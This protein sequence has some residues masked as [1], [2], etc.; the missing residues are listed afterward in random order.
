M[1]DKFG[2]YTSCF[3][4]LSLTEKIRLAG[5][6]G[7]GYIEI[8]AWPA[9]DETRNFAVHDIDFAHLDR[10]VPKIRTALKEHGVKISAI[11][12]Y[13]NTLDR[14]LERRKQ[15][16]GHLMR[17]VDAARMLDC[18]LVSTFIG[19]N[20]DLDVRGNFKELE[21]AF[22]PVLKY[23]GENG[24][25]IAFENCVMEGWQIQGVPGTL[26]YQPELWEEIFRIL[27]QD[28]LGINFD[29]S[30]LAKQM[31]D[32]EAAVRK[33]GSRIF[34]FHIKD[35]V[36]SSRL[37]NWYGIYNRQFSNA[38]KD[39]FWNSAIAGKGVLDWKKI[40]AALDEA[41]Y[42][43]VMSV[44]NED[45]D[46]QGSAER[47]RMGIVRSREYIREIQNS[48]SRGEKSWEERNCAQASLAAGTL[49]FKNI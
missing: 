44:E 40:M 18:P 17:C 45:P 42:D 2:F 47:T 36:I 4:G 27:P 21:E 5:E 34:H 15:V 8:G 43:G 30:H 14:D 33:F 23:A 12:Y 41:G 11:G 38:H 48:L 22:P 26:C 20:I 3:P 16:I 31:I 1:N 37:L 24:I 25:K 39:G 7:F 28:N 32:Y 10:Q 35:T 19:R 46:Y 29:P 13:E 6:E 9:G 49:H